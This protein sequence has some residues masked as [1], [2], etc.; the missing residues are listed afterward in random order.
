MIMEGYGQ[1]RIACRQN[2]G[3]RSTIAKEIPA[4]KETQISPISFLRKLTRARNPHNS[5]QIVFKN[6]YGPASFPILSF[7]KWEV[8]VCLFCSCSTTES[9]YWAWV[10][11]TTCLLSQR[12][13]IMRSYSWGGLC[14]T[15]I[16]DCV[17]RVFELQAVA[18][19]DLTNRLRV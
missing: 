18:G 13:L 3:P 8:L 5:C 9:V 6:W 1:E 16:F 15:Q 11:Q 19:W 17:S 7:S 12:L 4:G 2:Q 14:I 10:A